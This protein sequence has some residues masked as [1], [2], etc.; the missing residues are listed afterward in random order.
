MCKEQSYL[1]VAHC[2]LYGSRWSRCSK[3]QQTGFKNPCRLKNYFA[4][5]C[6]KLRNAVLR[7][8]RTHVNGQLFRIAGSYFKI[9]GNLHWRLRSREAK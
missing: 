3:I 5:P 9:A 2:V 6:S 7:I 8:T 1:F 4:L